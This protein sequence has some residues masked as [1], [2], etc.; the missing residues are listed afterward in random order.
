MIACR[1]P[2][3]R[4]AGRASM[5]VV[6]RST[7]EPLPVVYMSRAPA[8]PMMIPPVGKSGP[9]RRRSSSASDTS[10]SEISACSASTSSPKL[11]GGI[12]VAMPTAIPD[13]PLRRS[14]GS[15][16]GRTIGSRSD[17]SKLSVKSTVSR[18]T[19][20]SSESRARRCSLHSV[21]RIAAGGSGSL[22]PKLPWPSTSGARREKGCAIRT[23][24]SY[25]DWSPCGWNLPST[26]PTTLAHLRCEPSG[27][28]F[29]SLIA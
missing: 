20:V 16:A 19:S 15:R 1:E 7:T 23:S 4:A 29:S 18:A 27:E 21:Y 13:A 3:P 28:R 11:C 17:A 2:C 22:D 9:G 14:I 25:T 12:L 10:R 5:D 24:A 6:E 26:S 8:L